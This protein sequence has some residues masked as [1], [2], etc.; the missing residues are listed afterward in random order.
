[1][2]L[3]V[4]PYIQPGLEG[5]YIP[6][7]LIDPAG[8]SRV[9]TPLTLFE[10]NNQNG[11][12]P[13]KWDKLTV[14]TG[15][16]TDNFV[17]GSTTLSTGGGLANASAV[18]A[19]RYYIRYQVGKPIFFGASFNF[20][21]GVDGVSKK[22]G[23]FDANNGAFIEQNG[24]VINLT[25]RNNGV[26]TPTPQSQ[27][28]FDKMDGTGPSGLVFNPLASQDLRMDF[29]GSLG[30]RF[31]LYLGAQFNLVHVLEG[32]NSPMPL[33]IGTLNLTVRQEIVNLSGVAGST[34]FTVYNANVMSEGAT[35]QAV[36]FL[37]SAGRGTSLVA[38]TTRRPIFSIQ[39]KTLTI[40]GVNRN[41]GQIIGNTLS[42]ITDAN[43]FFEI[44]Q[45]GVL[46]GASFSSV[47][48]T[49]IANSDISA[50]AISGGA[51][52]TSGYLTA[53]GNGAN[54]TGSIPANILSQFPVVYSS[55][56]NTQ[57]TISLVVTS[58]SGTANCAGAITWSE[59]Y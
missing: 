29:F 8:R 24:S 58:M 25:T 43:L 9:G 35:E 54:S 59:L 13:F 30:I 20:G 3:P 19:S 37:T 27:W 6:N 7:P 49:S 33:S 44:I 22:N 45:N 40:N 50:T 48:P 41:F 15:T 46:T 12:N 28:N 53:T 17:G 52:V 23:F 39:A 18:R 42:L 14:G 55:L 31:Y 36:S 5:G 26:D 51:M 1:M 4:A 16:L 32:T 56:Q 21:Q 47:G 10:H 34:S 57:D 11:T 38:A 2:P